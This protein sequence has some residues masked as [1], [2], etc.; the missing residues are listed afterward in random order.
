MR[1]FVADGVNGVGARAAGLDDGRDYGVA[2]EANVPY[3]VVSRERYQG[4]LCLELANVPGGYG[5]VFPKGDHVNVGVGGWEREG[6]RMREHL[7]RFCREYAIPE[8]EPR[9]ASRLPAASSTRARA[10]RQGASRPA[11]RRR[12]ARRPALG[13]RDLRG[14]ALG[15]ARR[16]RD[17]RS[18]R[19]REGRSL[20]LRPESPAGT[21]FPACSRL[22]RE[23]R[24]R[25]V[26]AADVCG[27][28]S[29][30]V[31]KAIVALIGG[32]V[33]SPSAMRGPRRASL[34]IVEAIARAAGD[35]GRAYRT[36]SR[37]RP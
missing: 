2:L 24:A 31:W 34:R 33:P 28:R 3:G 8:S 19:G 32:E 26:P 14:A 17:A 21:L 18:A 27:R 9:G 11:R 1:H 29:P 4:R 36:P 37:L 22:G 20:R 10:S 35:P 16:R 15:E 12:G 6:P 13:G 23:G 25:P 7:A 5:W 30:Y